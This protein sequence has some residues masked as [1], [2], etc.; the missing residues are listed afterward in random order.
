MEIANNRCTNEVRSAKLLMSSDD[1]KRT[2]I[3]RAPIKGIKTNA[4]N[5]NSH[6]PSFL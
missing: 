5:I 2:R 3:T 6:I 1:L 4:L